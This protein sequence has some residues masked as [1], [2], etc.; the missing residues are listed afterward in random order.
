MTLAET[1]LQN[2]NDWRPNG[3]PSNGLHVSPETGWSV[4]LAG[5]HNGV[6][7]VRLTEL[8]VI[9]VDDAPAGLTVAAWATALAKRST[10]LLEKL[11]VLEVDTTRD[12]A[13]LRSDVPSQKGPIAAYYEVILTGLTSA[14]VRR[15]EADRAAHTPRVAVPFTVTHEVLGKLVDD[16]TTAGSLTA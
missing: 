15:Y 14:T 13:V 16:I 1:L 12:E 3:S 6:V 8:A 2:L 9:R 5:D 11:T 7:G 4:R 10:G